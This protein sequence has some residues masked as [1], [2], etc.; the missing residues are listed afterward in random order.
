MREFLAWRAKAHSEAFCR[1]GS[2]FEL[3]VKPQAGRWHGE[4]KPQ[5]IF[6]DGKTV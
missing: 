1:A 5:L 4:L 3:L 2:R 6:V